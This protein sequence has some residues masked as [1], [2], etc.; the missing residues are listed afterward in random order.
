VETVN[1]DLI[2]H[3]ADASVPVEELEEMM[4]AVDEVLDEIGAG[5]TPTLLVLNKVD[6]VDSDDRRMV[7]AVHRDAVAVSALTGEGLD[8]LRQR[9][10]R[11]FRAQLE[12]VELLVPY[13]RGA[14][15]SELHELAGDLEREDTSE[16]VRV[17]ARV[18][19]AVAERLRPYDLNGRR[20]E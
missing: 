7:A 17:T 5:E 11:S 8:E 3:V 18:P 15:L 4:R 14:V 6:A 12:R 9:I 19:A 10:E 2:L 20:G 13:A 16:G 1:A